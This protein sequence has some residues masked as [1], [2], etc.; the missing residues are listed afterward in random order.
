MML[1]PRK[2]I[3]PCSASVGAAGFRA[4]GTVVPLSEFNTATSTPGIA[5]PHEPA[6]CVSSRLHVQAPVHSDIP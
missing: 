3:S 5:K 1:R 2:Q 6:L 4:G